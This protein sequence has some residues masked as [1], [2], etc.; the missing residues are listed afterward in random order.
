M[1]MHKAEPSLSALLGAEG[2]AQAKAM[3]GL[4]EELTCPI[5]LDIYKEPTSAGCSH[6][7]CKDCIKEA[8]RGQRSPLRA[9]FHLRNIVQRH[10]RPS[11]PRLD[12]EASSR[13]KAPRRGRWTWLPVSSAWMSPS[14]P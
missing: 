10:L 14:R 12:E 8:L 13:T 4:K 2:T 6:S 7:F 1:D 5:C 9:N 11:L 3:A